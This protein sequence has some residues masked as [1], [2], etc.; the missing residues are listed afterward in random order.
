MPPMTPAPQ[1]AAGIYVRISS[2]PNQTRLGVERQEEDCREL[3]ARHG[4]R[5]HRV[6]EDND[7][8]AYSGKARP[9]YRALL[10]DVRD[11]VVKVVVAW[12]AD[13]IYRHPKDLE[14]F[15]D[16]VPAAGAHVATVKAGD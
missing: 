5:L 13:R 10:D 7:L 3:V 9:G 16:V 4:W 11:G 8:S 2:D 6:Y 15:I 1:T 14:G 12:H